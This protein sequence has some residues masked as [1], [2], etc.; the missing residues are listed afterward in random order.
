M[1]KEQK[2]SSGKFALGAI[3]GAAVGA[4]AALLTAPKSGKET[5]ED[6]KNKATEVSHEAL[7]QLRKVEGELNKRISDAKRLVG[8]YE[9]EAKREVENLITKAEKMKDRAVKMTEEL[10]ADTKNKVDERFLDDVRQVI[11]DLERL[12][13]HATERTKAKK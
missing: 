10:K 13:D 2:G 8:K 11:A 5:R 4:A 9:G 1:A 3:L 7:R 12:R 6:I